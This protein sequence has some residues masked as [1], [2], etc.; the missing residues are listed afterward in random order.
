MGNILNQSFRSQTNEFIE[1]PL[2]R[3][4]YVAVI[5]NRETARQQMGDALIKRLRD[6]CSEVFRMFPYAMVNVD[7][8]VLGEILQIESSRV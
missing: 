1:T 7:Y 3:S 2:R 8:K 6:I 4:I 5:N